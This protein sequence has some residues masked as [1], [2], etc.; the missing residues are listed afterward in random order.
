MEDW[1]NSQIQVNKSLI[2]ETCYV[3]YRNEL[4][5]LQELGIDSSFLLSADDENFN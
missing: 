2:T 1:P 4:Y 5:Y 3:D